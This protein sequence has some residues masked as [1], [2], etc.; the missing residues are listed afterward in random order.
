MCPVLDKHWRLVCSSESACADLV[1]DRPK[2]AVTSTLVAHTTSLIHHK[3]PLS[4][5]SYFCKTHWNSFIH[6]FTYHFSTWRMV[7][8]GLFKWSTL[9]TQ[10][11]CYQVQLLIDLLFKNFIGKQRC[12][13]CFVKH[14]IHSRCAAGISRGH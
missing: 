13:I 12:T 9:S 11:N 8:S 6:Y 14:F 3:V 10:L 7:I 5:P 1:H 2:A 4:R